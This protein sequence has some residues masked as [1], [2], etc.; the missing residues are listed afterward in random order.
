MRIAVLDDTLRVIR[1]MP[2]FDRLRDYDV[3]VVHEH[4][5]EPRALAERI[6]AVEVLLLN[7]ERT[8][9]TRELLQLLPE[10]K[11]ISQTGQA[12]P[13]IDV[14]ACTRRGIVI[15]AGGRA[16]M[17]TVE[18]TWALILASRR[19]IVLEA[20]A[21]REGRWQTGLGTTVRQRTLGIFGYGTIGRAVARIAP[22]F[23][24]QVLVWGRDRSLTRACE[25]GVAVASSQE[26]LFARSQMLT[27]HLQLNEGTRG[28]VRRA[29]LDLMA[30]ASLLVNTS[31]AGLIEPGALLAA[32]AAGCP[33][34]AALDVF[35]REPLD[36]T[37]PLLHMNN[38]LCTPHI[39]HV[40]SDA[41]EHFFGIAIEQILAFA[42]SA[43]IN[44][45][46]P[47]AVD[48]SRT[49]WP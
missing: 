39:G 28:I 3:N 26:D 29:H 6:G 8:P 44:V 22:A 47:D 24:M 15:C 34:H 45:M 30:P 18:L 43:P 11:L 12:I 7:R 33:G 14:P 25:D 16:P 4:V 20:Q 42:A 41:Y 19:R 32:L 2:G 49:G 40:E 38:V 1:R 27:L 31:R 23:G 5:A 37:D 10:L 48:A 21:A 46:N 35:D 17:A 9:I 13:H 36:Q